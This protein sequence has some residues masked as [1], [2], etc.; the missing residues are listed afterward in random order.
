VLKKLTTLFIGNTLA[1][2]CIAMVINS[3]LGCFAV[4][5]ANLAIANFFNISL[6][7]AGMLLELTLLLFATYKGEG[8]GITSIVNAIYGSYA[9]D[10]FRLLLPTHIGLIIGLLILPVGW[11]LM[12]KAGLGD[13]GSNIVMNALMK[14]TGKS[15]GFIRTIEECIFM[16]IGFI[17]A[18]QHMTWFTVVLSFGLGYLLQFVYKLIKYDPT[19][20]HHQFI[21]KTAGEIYGVNE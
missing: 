14:Q 11:A 3:G 8:I 20:I 19:E 15:V 4:T 9:L 16:T 13:T 2:L 6:G 18:R 5:S 12:G 21:I 10:F 7:T 1:A 17:G